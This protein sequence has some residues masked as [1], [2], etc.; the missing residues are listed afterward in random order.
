MESKK[1]LII[2]TFVLIIAV[3]L[4]AFGY[5]NWEKPYSGNIEP[6][7]VGME[8]NQ[9]S[10]LMYVAQNQGYFTKNGLNVIFKDYPSGAAAT[11]GMLNEEV[12]LAIAT[13]FVLTRNILSNTN[14]QTIGSIN[15][16]L[17]SYIIADKSSG[18]AEVSNLGGKRIGLTFQTNSE[19]YIARF[20]ELNSINLNQVSLVNVPP[21]QYTD[22]LV[23]GTV[24]AIVAWQP[25]IGEIQN[26]IGNDRVI[27]WDAHAGQAAYCC[28][29]TTNSWVNDHPE[30]TSRFLNALLQAENYVLS[31]PSTAKILLQNWLNLSD[32]YVETIW[33]QFNFGLSLEQ[34]QLLAMQDEGMWLIKNNLTNATYLPNF[35]NYLYLEGL[36]TVKPNAVTVIR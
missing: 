15:K 25:Y 12:N 19:F 28:I 29:I 10:L 14:I 2:V 1:A 36:V 31:D 35:L 21:F 13:E 17:Q 8:P 22:A 7:S 18:I 32:T 24:D 6:I 20:L 23:N 5:L 11:N 30:L 4:S 26:L 16:F 27:M 34:S 33:L 9:V 3:I